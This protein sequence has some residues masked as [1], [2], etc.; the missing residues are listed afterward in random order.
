M[1]GWQPPRDW[2]DGPAGPVNPAGTLGELLTAQAGRTPERVAIQQWARS[3]TYR[4]LAGQGRDLAAV[5]RAGGV[6]PEVRVGICVRRAPELVVGVL[7]IALAGGAYVPL[8]PEHPRQRLL[9]ILDD[10]G[11]DVVVADQVGRTALAGTG[12]TLIAP[13][14]HPAGEPVPPGV[15]PP[16][17][18]YVLYTSGSTGRPKGVV[19]S[20]GSAVAFG[21]AVRA[22]MPTGIG[23]R[24]AG[25]ASLGFDTSLFDLIHPLATGATVA[26][27]PEADRVDP[28]RLQRFLAHHRVTRA[29]L[30]P[31]VLPLLDPDALPELA[32][33]FVAGEPCGPE[34]VARWAVSGRRFLNWYGPTET[35]VIVT[36][37]ELSGTWTQPLPIGGPMPGCRAY[38]LDEG[39]RQCPPGEPGELC[40]G[41]PQLA[42][43]YLGR[44]G[45]T[46]DRFVPDPF[47]APGDRLYRTGDRVTWR[48]DG[49][50]A[51]LGRLDRQ[52]KIHGQRVEIGELETV[53]SGHPDV[54]QAVVDAVRDGAGAV[55]LDA[56]LTP[57]DGP[58]LPEVRAYCERLL[59][60]YMTPNRVVRLAELPLTVSG[61]VD[62]A[63]LR[64]TAPVTRTVAASGEV[65]VASVWAE[66]MG[67]PVPDGDTDFAAAGGHSLLAMRLASALR[68]RL[69]RR[70]EVAD[71]YLGRT[72]RGLTERVE[73]A[74]PV[75]E[76]LP[77]GSPAA[78]TPMQRRLWFVEQLS[79]GVP[80]HNIAMAQRI[81]GPL[82]ERSLRA[83]LRAVA[84]RQE[85]LRWRVPARHGSPTVVV[86]PPAAVP[87]AVH[88][89]SGS[90]DRDTELRAILDRA[91][92]TPFDLAAGPLWRVALVRLADHEHVLAITVHHLVFDG[93]SVDVLYRDIAAAYQESPGEPL[94]AGFADY[95]AWSAA[96]R[97]ADRAG[98]DRWSAHLAGAP[99]VLDLPADRARP[100]VQTFHG[101]AVDDRLEPVA[102][103]RVRELAVAGHTT[104]FVVLLAAFGQLLGRL[105]GR[106]ELI[107][108]T[109]VVDRGHEAFEPVI[110]CCLQ[111]LP[112]RL[113]ASGEPDFGTLVRA[114]DEELAVARANQ[115]APLEQLMDAL[116]CPRDLSRNPLV[117]VLFNMYNFAE[118]RLDLPGTTATELAAGLP[119]SL[120]DLT[121]Y[122]ADHDGGY[123][124]RA[125][126]NPDLFDHD[127][128]TALLAGYRT[129]VAT[130]T[131]APDAPAGTASLRTSLPDPTRALSTQDAPDPLR[132]FAAVDPDR[133]AVTGVG[134]TLTYAAATDLSRR[135]ASAIRAAGITTAVAVLAARD[136]LLAP[137]LLGVLAS[138][139]RWVILDPTGPEALL[140]A[141]LAAVPAAAVIRL[142]DAPGIDLP[143]LDLNGTADF[144]P[145]GD[146]G[147]YSLTSG[148]TG[149]PS[150]VLAT[151]RPL[152]HFLAW[153]ERTFDLT[154]ADRFA[155]LGG[156]A[157]DPLLRDAFTPLVLGATLSVPPQEM[158]REPGAL[159]AWLDAE[160]VTVLHL[161]PQ[162]AR[163]LAGT[164]T[165]LPQVRLALLGGDQLADV[166][167][168]P[169][170]A[171]LPHARLVNCYGTTETPQVQSWHEITGPA[172]AEPGGHPVPVGHGI[173][174]AELVVLTAHGSPAGVGELGEVVIRGHHLATGYADAEQTA[175][176][177]GVDGPVT[178]GWFRTG[179]LGRH[180]PGGAVVLA[181]RLDDQV[182]IRGFRVELGAVEAALAGHP[183]VRQARVLAVTENGERALRGY[184]VPDRAGVR[185]W[186][187]KEDLRGRLPDYAVPAQV[188]L[189]PEL[190]LTRNGKIDTTALRALAPAVEREQSAELTGRTERVIAGVWSE[191]LGLPRPRA[192]DNFF[193]VGG[194]S[195]AIVVV[196]DR[197]AELLGRAIPVVDLFR[198]P[199][200]G[201]LAAHLDGAGA[202][203]E[204]ERAVARAAWRRTR[205]RRRAVPRP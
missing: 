197:L 156:L 55:R 185:A 193:E 6:G 61:K 160:R 9:T 204:V 118:A 35:T 66:I 199:T 41:G 95:V 152:A 84:T 70:V 109:P 43:G 202:D 159:A 195:L 24:S 200:I 105:A 21:D 173:D 20:H 112:L 148:S 170:R 44:P 79:P 168:A 1:T 153:Y 45:L 157:H 134:G 67:G 163:L 97:T 143:T 85:V 162:L 12:R 126:Y 2:T 172:P 58:D 142:A 13:D 32:E 184:V 37:T 128:I 50:I 174:G 51:F 165:A 166:D 46:A 188:V 205:A 49:Q 192:G 113:N 69:G 93:W 177:F 23:C 176:R 65:S 151:D 149:T 196:R 122:V 8:D 11:V 64:A 137:V 178:G 78:L 91:A 171:L 60:R 103:Q 203:D 115:D 26:L 53:L 169:L 100:S 47:G 62:M 29:M 31:A 121:L 127:R 107:V 155:L 198:H 87:L 183:A 57:A 124:L 139:A 75:A 187:L 180:L 106:S 186:Q 80:A 14:G 101:A 108:G 77:S 5:L 181:G 190:P 189:L 4:E 117:Q 25:F 175:A 130:L 42:R 131:A 38:V 82:D 145:A 71:V 30:P 33:L 132:R 10:A 110:G 104:P 56:Y 96:R 150:P 136:V 154:S 54:R 63:A 179:D 73:A 102:A 133:V 98:L 141:Q 164:G 40:I 144:A 138:G 120:Y 111:L 119:G 68:A 89:L 48:T 140:A 16:H 3:M 34:Q 19:V 125:V 88:D 7:G 36:G 18:A 86:D 158:L 99:T 90:P 28:L 92:T 39:M 83:A 167:I 76:T 27:L 201:A 94:A 72:V 52:V 15:G 194:H 59:P 146:R 114:A 161:T 74:A 147:Y 123:D 17:A 182:K 22:A 116:G 129:L 81:D 191:V 135:T